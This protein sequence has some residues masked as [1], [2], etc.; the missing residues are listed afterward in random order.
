MKWKLLIAAVLIC[1]LAGVIGSV[2][3]FSSIPTW[4][5]TLVKPDFAPP[6][7]LFGPVWIILYA[8]MGV[9]A[10]LIYET[11]KKDALKIFG[12]QLALNASWSIVFFGLRSV[13][14]GLLVIF[15]LWLSIALTILSFLKV[16]KTAAYL[17]IPYI[18]WVS[19][20]SVLNYFI[21]ILN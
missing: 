14:G 10:Y 1:E 13:S 4:Y 3:T 7:W 5:A 20:A 18:L 17:L 6:N 16:S 11:G 2:F 9:S 15:L 19:F 8:M 12:L 21:F